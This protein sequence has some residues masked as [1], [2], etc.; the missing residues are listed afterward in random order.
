M[1]YCIAD[2]IATYQLDP[3][4]IVNDATEC[5]LLAATTDPNEGLNVCGEDV[6]EINGI[7]TVYALVIYGGIFGTIPLLIF[8]IKP[9]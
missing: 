5:V 9:L 8:G 1:F 2:L 4:T 6:F 7:W 3:K